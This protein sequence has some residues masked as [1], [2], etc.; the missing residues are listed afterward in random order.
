VDNYTEK[1]RNDSGLQMRMD[2]DDRTSMT[3]DVG[4]GTSYAISTGWGVLV[5]QARVEWEHEFDQDAQNLATVYVLDAS[6]NRFNL[7]GDDPDRD[8]FNVGAGISAIFAHGMM[9]FVNYEGLVGY[10]DLSRH[11]V[12]AG[13]RMEF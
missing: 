7:E 5:P 4:L 11:R 2:V 9:A 10:D 8:Y 6:Q 3:T 12:T 13:L 1:D